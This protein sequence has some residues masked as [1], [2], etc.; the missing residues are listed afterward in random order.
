[1]GILHDGCLAKSRMYVTVAGLGSENAVFCRARRHKPQIR[2]CLKLSTFPCWLLQLRLFLRSVAGDTTSKVAY[3]VLDNER[4]TALLADEGK[5][6]EQAGMQHRRE[7][8]N[9]VARTHWH[10][11]PVHGVRDALCCRMF[12]C[13]GSWALFARC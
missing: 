10:C 4:L 1:M 11:V 6:S 2:L 8:R 3:R 13:C 7:R 12:C 9:G 5:V